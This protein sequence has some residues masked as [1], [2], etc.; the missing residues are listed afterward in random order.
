MKRLIACVAGAL[1]IGALP[2]MAS[3]ATQEKPKA[4]ETKTHTASGT[5]S[6]VSGTSLTVKTSKEELTFTI[7]EKTDVVGTGASTKTQAMKQAGQ[8]TTLTDFVASGDTV[9][10]RYHETGTEKHAARVT[11]TRKAAVKK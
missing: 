6:A 5:V 4:D 10:V 8:K 2:A 9:T 11:V 7:D 1:L 3:Q